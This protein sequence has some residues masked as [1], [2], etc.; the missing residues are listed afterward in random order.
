MRRR[1]FV[2]VVGGAAAWPL[3]VRAQQSATR[4]LIGVLSPISPAAAK[5]NIEGLREGLRALGYA[6]GHNVSPELRFAEGVVARLPELASDLVTLKPDVT[7]RRSQCH[8][9]Y[10]THLLDN[11]RSGCLR[12]GQQ[13][14][15]TGR[16]YHRCLVVWG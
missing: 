15:Q 13:H 12:L 7:P 14:H 8:D 6:E 2:A 11:R 5:R 4:P 16:P 10:S 3:A 1:D 9:N